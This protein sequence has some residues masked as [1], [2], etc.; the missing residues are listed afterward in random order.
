MR[1]IAAFIVFVNVLSAAP[2]WVPIQKADAFDRTMQDSKDYEVVL[3]ADYE[4][5]ACEI[6]PEYV[7]VRIKRGVLVGDFYDK[8]QAD[9][10]E[11]KNNEYRITLK[12][13]DR[14]FPWKEVLFTAALS[15][16]AGFA[17]GASIRK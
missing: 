4:I 12:P 16:A 14:P 17:A 15:I 1:L 10:C 5:T 3:R 6:K 11:F 2:N 7:V 13:I 8:V 9:K